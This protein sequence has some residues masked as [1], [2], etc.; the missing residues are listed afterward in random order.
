MRTAPLAVDGRPVATTVVADTYLARLR[1]MLGRTPLP[2]AM[3]LVPCAS[4]HGVGMRTSL[5][6]AFVA[7][8]GEVL[9]TGVLR[10][11]AFLGAPRGTRAVLEAPTGS[12]ARWGLTT[13]A[14][15]ARPDT[16]PLHA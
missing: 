8:D 11:Y 2:E 4:V 7:P 6:V 16:S 9:G 3:F 14:R 12:F 10:P 15:L 13:G 1:G 5:D